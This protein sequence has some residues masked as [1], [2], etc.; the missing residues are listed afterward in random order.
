MET[1]K[2]SNVIAKYVKDNLSPT[3]KEKILI[4]K[5]YDQICKLL[6][7]N[8]IFQTGSYAR[9][10]SI[11]PVNDLDIIWVIPRTL[12]DQKLHTFGISEKAIDPQKLDL[13]DILTDLAKKLKQEYT[14][15]GIKVETRAQTHSV[16]V[17]FD[18]EDEFSI[19][20]VPAIKSGEKNEF[21]DDTFKIPEDKGGKIFWKRSD[22]KGSIKE[23]QLLN[24]IN[25]AFRKTAKFLK[26]WKA[27]CKKI[28]ESFALKSLHLETISKEVIKQNTDISIY[29]AL[30]SIYSDFDYYLSEPRFRD[31]AE[32]TKFVDDYVG[33]LSEKEIELIV[34]MKERALNNLEKI[35]DCNDESE[36]I[37]IIESMFAET[38]S[39]SLQISNMV[40]SLARQ[41]ITPSWQKPIPFT[42]RI[43]GKIQIRCLLNNGKEIFSNRVVFPYCNLK[44]IAEPDDDLVYD[45]IYWQVVNTGD[46]VLEL[47]ESALR[48]EFFRGKDLGGEKTANPLINWEMSLYHGK[49]WIKCIAVKNNECIAESDSFYLNVFNRKFYK[50]RNF[51]KRR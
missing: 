44:Y 28:N 51:I 18:S 35:R 24:D 22:P 17:M 12:I 27:S 19:D 45:Q 43:I 46:E 38:E 33:E 25:N 13:S 23:A 2:I 49:H 3:D 10:T 36:V 21:G 15:I 4:S 14:N 42:K 50:Q 16:C 31:R 9:F 6:T 39:L 8:E 5:K 1:K 7:G 32:S 11:T 40:L 47:G 30:I 34:K 20:V 26:K 37:K 41:L 29:D 48:G